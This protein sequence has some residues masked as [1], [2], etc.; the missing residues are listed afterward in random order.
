MKVELPGSTTPSEG[1]AKGHIILTATQN[2]PILGDIMVK[3]LAK[4]D[5]SH[6]GEAISVEGEARSHLL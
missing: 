4:N 6:S 2:S 3:L 1:L 5:D